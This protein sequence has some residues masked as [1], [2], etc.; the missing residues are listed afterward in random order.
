M[1]IGKTVI[2][3]EVPIPTEMTPLF[4]P[5]QRGKP[6]TKEPAPLVAPPAKVPTRPARVPALVPS[7][8]NVPA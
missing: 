3:I 8:P 4:D 5:R 1:N 7:K 6:D 2:V